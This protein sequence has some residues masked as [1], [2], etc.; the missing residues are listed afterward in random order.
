MKKYLKTESVNSTKTVGKQKSDSSNLI[1]DSIE[2]QPTPFQEN[3]HLQ[4][5]PTESSSILQ[6]SLISES[7]ELQ[8]TTSQ[9]NIETFEP[10]VSDNND[11]TQDANIL[12]NNDASTND[13]QI[14]C[15][16]LPFRKAD[17]NQFRCSV[18][19][20]IEETDGEGDIDDNQA[21]DWSSSDEEESIDDE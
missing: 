19:P 6:P 17:T 2:S 4:N 13:Y 10:D 7:I 12:T 20:N 15:V 3:R 1:S 11:S 8:S 21:T 16:M 5:L 18:L 9:E 14:V